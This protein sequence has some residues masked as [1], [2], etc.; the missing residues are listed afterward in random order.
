MGYLEGKRILLIGIGFYDYEESIKKCIEEQGALVNYLNSCP[1]DFLSRFFLRVN[2]SGWSVAR[3]QR[4]R[5]EKLHSL[6]VNNDIVFVIKGENLTQED[7]AYLHKHN[8]RARFILY[9]WDSLIR[10]T[11]LDVLLPNFDNILSFDRI[12]CLSNPKFK[13]RPL[14]YRILPVTRP[15]EYYLSF[16]GWMHS[17]RLAIVRSIRN[18]LKAQGKNYFIKLYMGKFSYFF[19]RY[20]TRILNSDDREL[21]TLKP[22]PYGEYQR[23]TAASRIVLD[24]AHPLQSGLTIRTIETLAAG[25]HLMT[26]NADIVNYPQISTD[27]YTIFE[28]EHPG[29]PMQIIST[30]PIS[31]Y[32]SIETFIKNILDEK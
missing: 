2:M 3:L 19:A 29:L 24:I 10:H 32:F 21:I 20:V 31:D 7:L 11:N 25:C 18:Q 27:S 8:P 5:T 22:I 1:N 9:L 6:P 14:F 15:K 17:D 26:T 12:D 23:V 4:L 16:I 28:R 13:F 30:E